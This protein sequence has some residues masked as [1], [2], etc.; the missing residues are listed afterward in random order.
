[1]E[2]LVDTAPEVVL[3][4]PLVVEDRAELVDQVVVDLLAQLVEDGVTARAR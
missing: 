4:Q 3:G 2:L 1:M